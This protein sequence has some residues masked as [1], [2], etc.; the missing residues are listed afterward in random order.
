MWKG[1]YSTPDPDIAES[2][3]QPYTCKNGKKYKAILQNR[4]EF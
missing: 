2:Y 3:A 4:I 1:V